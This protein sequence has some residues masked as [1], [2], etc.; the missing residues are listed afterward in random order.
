M[1]T[2]LWILTIAANAV[3]CF[4]SRHAGVKY[5][6]R[7]ALVIIDDKEDAMPSADACCKAA[8]RDV[9]RDIDRGRMPT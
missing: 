3:A 9:R 4:L 6:R 5:E 8:L 7:R 2:E 1:T